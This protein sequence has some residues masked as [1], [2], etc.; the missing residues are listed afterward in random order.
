M[1]HELWD[2]AVKLRFVG[3]LQGSVASQA[4]MAPAGRPSEAIDHLTELLVV[5]VALDEE[6]LAGWETR[7]QTGIAR[8]EKPA[9]RHRQPYQPGVIAPPV[10]GV[11]AQHPEPLG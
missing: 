1:P 4:P 8:Q 6:T 7:R 10:D 2:P 3:C 5:M 11:V 9:L